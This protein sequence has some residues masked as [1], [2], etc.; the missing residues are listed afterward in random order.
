M[1]LLLLTH[2]YLGMGM[3]TLMVMWCLSGVVMMY[4]NYPALDEASRVRQLTPIIWDGCCKISGEA[5][6]DEDSV[7]GLQL[8][9]LAGAPVLRLVGKQASRVIDLHTGLAIAGVSTEQAALVAATYAQASSPKTPERIALIDYDQWTVSGEFD[10][11]RPLYRIDWHDGIGTEVYVSSATGRAVQMTTAGE[12]FWNWLGSVPHWLYFAQVRHHA[13]LWSGI[14]ISTSLIGCFLAAIG[15][16]IGV[17]QW[18]RQPKGRWTPYQGFNRWHHIAGLVVGVFTLSWIVSG[19][20]SMNPWGWLEGAGAQQERTLIR[21]GPATTGRQIKAALQAFA[22]ARPAELASL[23][24]APINGGLYFIATAS[25][26]ERSRFSAV[27]VSA[28]LK[29]AD[30]AYVAG[31]LGGTR[32]APAL[33][34]ITQED[35]YHFSHHGEPAQL[36]VFRLILADGTRYYLDAVSGGLIAKLDRSARAYRWLHEGLHRMDFTAA[37]RGRPQWDLLV[38]V[39]MSGAT[40]LCVTGAYL[41]IR[42]MFAS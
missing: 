34:L 8:E 27:A 33:E 29:D 35:A 41:G 38:L 16:Y 25:G 19:M 17:L 21:N 13:S 26:G 5:L 10:S 23:K 15:I 14:V 9:M 4:H 36:P 32:S 42:R 2:R 31:A 20:L 12:R 7:E 6:A 1:R 24:S 30:L 39:L 40:L 11:E 37:M 28:P 3:G 18:V 22:S